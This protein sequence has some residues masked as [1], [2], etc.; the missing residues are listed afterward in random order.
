MIRHNNNTMREKIINYII[1]LIRYPNSITLFFIDFFSWG[2]F[3]EMFDKECRN[4]ILSIIIKRTDAEGPHPWG[5]LYFV[6]QLQI[7]KNSL[8]NLHVPKH[9]LDLL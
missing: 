2:I 7:M 4:M 1:N 5:L 8:G 6:Q 9:I 3:N